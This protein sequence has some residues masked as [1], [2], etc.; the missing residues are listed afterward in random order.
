M[1]GR[2]VAVKVLSERFLTDPDAVRR[3]EREARAAAKASQHPHVVTIYDVGEH[4]GRPF[5]VMELMSG[6]SLADH[7][8]RRA[9]CARGRSALDRG[10]RGRAGPRAR[11]RDHPS[12]RQAREPAAGRPRPPRRGRLRDRPAGFRVGGHA[13]RPGAGD[14]GLRL[15]RAGARGGRQRGQRPLLARRGR[16]RAADR[17]QALRRRN[18]GGPGPPAPGGRSHARRRARAGPAARR[19]RRAAPW[20]GQGARGPLAVGHRLRRGPR[21]RHRARAGP[22]LPADHPADGAPHAHP[23]R[24][25]ACGPPPP[26]R[27]A[28]PGGPPGRGPARRDP[29]DRAFRRR[30]RVAAGGEDHAHGPDH[31]AARADEYALDAGRHAAGRPPATAR[32]LPRSTIAASRS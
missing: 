2:A 31:A 22:R 24:R 20:A 26:P 5:I 16:L 7:P 14:R 18:A 4:D 9:A 11:A 17:D 21:R 28:D 1:L 12:R 25:P 32:A 19:R 30:R 23:A 8:A 6:G 29:G 15:A 10:G 3:F 13:D 27:A